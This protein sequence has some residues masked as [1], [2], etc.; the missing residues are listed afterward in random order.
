MKILTESEVYQ[1][2]FESNGRAVSYQDAPDWYCGTRRCTHMARDGM[3]GV[4]Y[5]EGGTCQS[6]ASSL[7]DK[8]VAYRLALDYAA[9]AHRIIIR[10]GKELDAE[11]TRKNPRHK[12]LAK[13]SDEVRIAQR[14]RTAAEKQIAELTA[15]YFRGYEGR[16]LI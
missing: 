8:I 5:G 16:L 9:D 13:L 12:R 2:I 10:A 6:L 15:K 11:Y 7:R 14:S 1:L 3:D 4:G